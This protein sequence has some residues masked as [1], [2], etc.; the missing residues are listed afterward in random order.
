MRPMAQRLCTW[1]TRWGRM[2][3][4]VGRG[5]QLCLW[6][7]P[8]LGVSQAIISPSIVSADWPQGLPRLAK[9]KGGCLG[10]KRLT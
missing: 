4:C 3:R 5:Q 2:S 7:S 10:V 8:P 1:G 9:T 6:L